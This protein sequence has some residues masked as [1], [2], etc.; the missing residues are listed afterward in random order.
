VIAFNRELEHAMEVGLTRGFEGVA[1]GAMINEEKLKKYSNNFIP[2]NPIGTENFKSIVLIS[3]DFP[4]NH[5]G[6]IATFT[7]DLAVALAAEGNLV[8]IITQSHDINRVDFEN[9]VWVHRVIIRDILRSSL[10]LEH[11]IPQHI[12]IGQQPRLRKQDVF[13]LTVRLILWRRR[14]GIAKGS[15]LV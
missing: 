13:P 11:S 8:H 15:L 10:A 12:G 7:K 1:T 2:F 6:G 4:P 14:Y 5:V 3:H 9:G